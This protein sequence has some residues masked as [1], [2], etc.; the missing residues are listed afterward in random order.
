MSSTLLN[1]ALR[2]ASIFFFS[3]TENVVW[4]IFWYLIG[5]SIDENYDN[6]NAKARSGRGQ[7]WLDVGIDSG[8]GVRVGVVSFRWSR[9]LQ[10]SCWKL[11][12]KYAQMH[13]CMRAL[14]PRR[15]PFAKNCKEILREKLLRDNFISRY[16]M[17][18]LAFERLWFHIVIYV[19]WFFLKVAIGWYLLSLLSPNSWLDRREKRWRNVRWWCVTSE[20]IRFWCWRWWFG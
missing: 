14:T 16:S 4:Y 10:V 13:I 2:S 6:G 3:F 19:T 18:P 17:W 5:N 7:L 11:P 1:M 8:K 9:I 15:I 12:G 20:G